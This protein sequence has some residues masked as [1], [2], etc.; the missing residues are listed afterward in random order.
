MSESNSTPLIRKNI[1]LKELLTLATPDELT[2]L[3]DILLNQEKKRL[4]YN[5]G[6]RQQL[7]QYRAQGEL[8]KA[9]SIIETEILALGSNTIALAF[10]KG[11]TVSYDEV[12]R[13]VARKLDI[14]VPQGDTVHEVEQR[15]LEDLHSKLSEYENLEDK[16]TLSDDVELALNS[17]RLLLS[18]R[19]EG[20]KP[21]SSSQQEDRFNSH[22]FSTYASLIAGSATV[23][24]L[25]VS[26][27]GPV[28]AG[29]SAVSAYKK[30]APVLEL[31]IP[32]VIQIA[33]IRQ[34]VINEDYEDFFSKLRGCL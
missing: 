12:V 14:E 17:L 33:L 19:I 4:F 26:V 34:S 1:E 30:T 23:A 29:I 32:A 20:R 22:E 28:V 25:S 24:A 21:L 13:D 16:K 6:A 15:I 10:R 27:I 3:V 11:A 9:A 5:D 2:V 31:I 8:Y 18:Y 7:R